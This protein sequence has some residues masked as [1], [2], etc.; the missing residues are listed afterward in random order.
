MEFLDAADQGASSTQLR[1]RLTD[2]TDP[3]RFFRLGASGTP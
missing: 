2:A 1:F 3:T